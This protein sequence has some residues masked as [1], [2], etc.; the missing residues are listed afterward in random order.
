MEKINISTN[1]HL[2]PPIGILW[3]EIYKYNKSVLSKCLRLSS[4]QHQLQLKNRLC[5]QEVRMLATPCCASVFIS[6]LW[7]FLYIFL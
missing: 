4:V 6:S 3:A 5:A 7:L 2:T 1:L